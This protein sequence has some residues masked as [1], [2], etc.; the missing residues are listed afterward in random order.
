MPVWN[1]QAKMANA[2]ATH[3]KANMVSP[4]LALM[5]SSLTLL[6]VFLKIMNMTV[7]MM[8]ATAQRRAL[9]KLRMERANVH[10]RVR[11]LRG[12][13]NMRTKERQAEVRKKP[14]M[15]WEASLMRLRISL[16]SA[17]R[18]T[19]QRCVSDVETERGGTY[20]MLQPATHSSGS[21]QG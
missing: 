8:E 14:N 2:L 18:A 10:H 21:R 11:T 12:F 16:I 13:R 4:M 7:A 9:M 1:S 3:I 20:W 19:A 5:F 6:I 15:T 17:G